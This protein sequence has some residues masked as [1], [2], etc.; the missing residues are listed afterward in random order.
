[1]GHRLHLGQAVTCGCGI[2][3]AAYWYAAIT[4]GT[5]GETDYEYGYFCYAHKP[6]P[7]DLKPRGREHWVILDRTVRRLTHAAVPRPGS[8]GT[9][10]SPP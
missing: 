7:A 8:S 4:Y 5:D 1:M 3:S 6:R 9:H 10:P 2:P